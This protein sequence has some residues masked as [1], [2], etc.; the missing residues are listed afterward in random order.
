M[1]E[2]WRNAFGIL[3]CMEICDGAGTG[4]CDGAPSTALVF[5]LFLFSCAKKKKQQKKKKKQKKKKTYRQRIF[6]SQSE[7]P[8]LSSLSR[9]SSL[10]SFNK[11]VVLVRILMPET[12]DCHARISRGDRMTIENIS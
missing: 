3:M 8:K 9:L 10:S 2:D 6:D 4:I 11:L 7:N 12:D 5:F 1:D